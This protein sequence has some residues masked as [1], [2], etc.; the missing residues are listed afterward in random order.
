MST[1]K[2]PASIRQ[3]FG[4]L[5]ARTTSGSDQIPHIPGRRS[6]SVPVEASSH[7]GYDSDMNNSYHGGTSHH[8]QQ[9]EGNHTKSNQHEGNHLHSRIATELTPQSC[10]PLAE[11]QPPLADFSAVYQRWSSIHRVLEPLCCKKQDRI[12]NPIGLL[13]V[14]IIEGFGLPASDLWVTSDPYCIATLT[15]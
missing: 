12:Q 8:E 3:R 14:D 15:G 4:S 10:L 11:T 7:G 2:K 9:Q 13:E 1:S 5:M 6:D